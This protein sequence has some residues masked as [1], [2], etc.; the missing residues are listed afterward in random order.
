MLGRRLAITTALLPVS[1]AWHSSAM[2]NDRL[3]SNLVRDGRCS[4]KTAIALRQVDRAN[5]VGSANRAAAYE[6]RPLPIGHSVTISAPH[7]H[8]ACVEMLPQLKQGAAALDVGVGSGYLAAVF[9]ALVGP[10]GRVVGIDRVPELVQMAEQNLRRNDAALLETGRVKLALAD[11]WRGLDEDRGPWDAIHV[12]AAAEQ[13]PTALVEQLKPG[14]RM[15]IP[16]GPDGGTQ[17]LVQVDKLETGRVETTALMGVRYVPLVQGLGE[18]AG[19][20][21]EL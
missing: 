20:K 17:Q 11:G 7:M 12:G 3:I 1:R 16:V 5:F 2:S 10:S 6:D 14:G 9:A 13:I 15:I 21:H 19:G 8:A 4:E 18:G